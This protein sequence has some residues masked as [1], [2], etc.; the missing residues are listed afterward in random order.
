M[1]KRRL[2]S[3]D[4]IV[5]WAAVSAAAS[6]ARASDRKAVRCSLRSQ[7]LISHPQRVVRV[8]AIER[9]RFPLHEWPVDS[10]LPR[11]AGRAA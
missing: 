4:D 10:G 5:S 9:G 3:M 1:E 7:V 6:P 11:R 2:D 8:F